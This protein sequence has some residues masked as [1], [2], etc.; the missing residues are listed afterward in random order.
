V[1]AK[2]QESTTIKLIPLNYWALT[3]INYHPKKYTCQNLNTTKRKVFDARRK[4]HLFTTKLNWIHSAFPI[5]HITSKCTYSAVVASVDN[6]AINETPLVIS[7]TT[8]DSTS[9]PEPKN[10]SQEGWV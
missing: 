10:L 8:E 9:D 2:C 1:F 4:N 6:I 7:S 5:E 3:T